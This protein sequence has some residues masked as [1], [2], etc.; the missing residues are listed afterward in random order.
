MSPAPPHPLLR[1]LFDAAVASAQPAQPAAMT[2]AS[3]PQCGCIARACCA[4]A[5]AR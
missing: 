3:G 4:C 2:P 1:R 5:Q